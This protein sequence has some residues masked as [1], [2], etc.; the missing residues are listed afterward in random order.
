MI[1]L[2]DGLSTDLAHLCEAS[3][4]GAVVQASAIPLA[5][6]ATLQQALHGGE[7]YELLFTVP[8]GK[9]VPSTVGGVKV[10]CIGEMVASSASAMWIA[11]GGMRKKLLPRGWEHFRK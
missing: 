11:S 1:D 3:G 2:S 8:A 9:R 5:R 4:T 6:S 10:T 7:D